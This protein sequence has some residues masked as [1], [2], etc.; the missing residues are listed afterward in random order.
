MTTIFDAPPERKVPGVTSGAIRPELNAVG[1]VTGAEGGTLDD[2]PRDLLIDAGW[3]HAG[4]EDITMPGTGRLIER[5]YTATE[6]EAI[7][8]GAVSLDL[9]AEQAFSQ[10][11]DRTCDVYLNARAFWQNIPIKVWDYYIGGYQVVKKWLS[12][13]EGKLLGRALTVEEARYVRD[14]ARRIAALCLLQPQLDANYAAVK[15]DTFPWNAG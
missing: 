13:R 2:P 8:H 7:A 6:R 10:L 5:D 12:Y 9:T 1:N 11:G 14:I 15:A 4:K 3:G